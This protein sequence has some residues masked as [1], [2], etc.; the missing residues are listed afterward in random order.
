VHNSDPSDVIVKGMGSSPRGKWSISV[1]TL[2]SQMQTSSSKT[3]TSCS[4]SS[5][6]HNL[7]HPD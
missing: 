4:P 3:L 7:R 6:S 5:V 1:L 2:T